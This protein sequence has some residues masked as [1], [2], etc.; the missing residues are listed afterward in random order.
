MKRL[1]LIFLLCLPAAAQRDFLTTDETDRV[2]EAQEPNERLQLYAKFAHQ[3]IDQVRSLI[4]GSKPG[5]SAL[6]HD[7]LEDYGNIVDAIDT[8]ADD[9][10]KH[11]KD[12]ALGNAAV[13]KLEQQMMKT[14][15]EIE[16]SK[17]KDISRYDFVLKQAIDSTKESIELA[18]ADLGKRTTDVVAKD[19]QEKKDIKAMAANKPEEEKKKA[20]DGPLEEKTERKAPSLYKKGEVKPDKPDKPN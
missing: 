2:R 7:L 10:L 4:A 1:I 14:L 9:A 18:N 6:I 15:Q 13:A 3:R 17:P 19:E 8:V 16:D 12:I 20:N 11:H 5:R